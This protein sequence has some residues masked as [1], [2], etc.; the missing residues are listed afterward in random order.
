MQKS[1]ILAKFREFVNLIEKRSGLKTKRLSLENQ[2]VKGLRSE[3]GGE[4]VSN[5]F[6]DFCNYHGIQHEPTIP[7]SP[8]QNGIAE[9]MNRTLV[10][11]VRSMLHHSQKLL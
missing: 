3:N 11:T 10:E 9:C 6:E 2:T 7:Y 8:Q 4:H 1:E 5:D